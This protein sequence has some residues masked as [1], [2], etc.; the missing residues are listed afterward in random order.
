M[1]ASVLIVDDDPV[2]RALARSVLADGGLTVVG[3]ADSV[4]AA[5]AA[6]TKLKPAAVLVDVGLPDGDGF[7]L[8]RELTALPWHPRVVLTSVDGDAG[9]AVEVA[10]SGAGAFVAKADLPNAPLAK[11]LGAP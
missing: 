7:A 8:A 9:S 5:V 6:A 4:S 10:R 11:L 1:A 3:E 2:F